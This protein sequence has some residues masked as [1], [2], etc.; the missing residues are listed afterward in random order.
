M[1]EKESVSQALCPGQA[2]AVTEAIFVNMGQD[3]RYP[4]EIVGTDYGGDWNRYL[5][6]M[7]AWHGIDLSLIGK[8]PEN[9]G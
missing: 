9:A 4:A 8:V 2:E 3:D 5:R 7:A 6:D 1:G